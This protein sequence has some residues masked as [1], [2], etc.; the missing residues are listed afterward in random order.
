[1][2]TVLIGLVL[3]LLLAVQSP[4][5]PIGIKIEALRLATTAVAL[6]QQAE[7]VSL[8]AEKT[9]LFTGTAMTTVTI[10]PTESEENTDTSIDSVRYCI[11]RGHYGPLNDVCL[12]YDDGS[13]D[14]GV[15]F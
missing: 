2:N 12:E 15:Q 3:Q 10:I 7:N 14:P 6:D 13:R 8:Q 11:W 4:N 5:I 1:M 9:V